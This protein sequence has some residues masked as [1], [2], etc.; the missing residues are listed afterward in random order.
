MGTTSRV[1][2]A[3]PASP[4][5][6]RE[7]TRGASQAALWLRALRLQQWVK[8]LLIFLPL[9][10][11]HR[12]G[13]WDLLFR[14]LLAFFAFGFAASAG[15]I[16]NDLLDLEADRAHPRKRHRPFA[17]GELSSAAGLVVAP[18]LLAAGMTLALFLPGGALAALGAYLLLTTTYSLLLKQVALLDM[19]ALAALYTLRIFAGSLATGVPVSEWLLAFSIFVFL[20]LAAVKRYSEVLRLRRESDVVARVAGRGYYPGDLELIRPLGLSSG[21]IAVLVLALYIN[22]ATVTRLYSRPALL[23]LIGPLLWFWISRVWLLAHRGEMKEDPVFFAVRDP[24][25]W[26]VAAAAG[27]AILLA[28]SVA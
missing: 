19:L 11:A 7:A 27:L 10:L 14:S 25:T 9:L 5:I 4:A 12:I 26:G 18:L 23:W 6:G 28:A 8:N 13:E 2:A 15:Y 21:M 1:S 3:L 22:S 20:S 17:S 24:V 16:V